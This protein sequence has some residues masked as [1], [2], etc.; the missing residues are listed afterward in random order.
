MH[1]GLSPFL[2]HYVA[3]GLLAH[4]S[5]GARGVRIAHNFI[6]CAQIYAGRIRWAYMLGAYKRLDMSE[7]AGRSCLAKAQSQL[8]AQYALEGGSLDVR[9]LKL[10]S[11]CS[12]T[13]CRKENGMDVVYCEKRREREKRRENDERREWEEREV[14]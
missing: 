14:A 10:H 12:K 9:L 4:P 8:L 1:A 3:L 13:K 7:R 11:K 2:P 5:L 6:S